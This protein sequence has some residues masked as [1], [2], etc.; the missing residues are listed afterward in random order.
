MR[1]IAPLLTAAV[2]AA[3]CA[4]PPDRPAA[5]PQS[6]TQLAQ[7]VMPVGLGWARNSINAVIFRGSSVASFGDMQYTA[8]YDADAHVILARRRLGSTTWEIVQT[9]YVGKVDDAH[10]AISLGVDGKGVLHMAWGGHNRPLLYAHAV[11]PGSLELSD[12]LAMTGQAEARVTYPQFY[13]L[14]DGD[15]LFL[16]RDG[17]SGSGDVMLNRY[18]VQSGVWSVVS[19][20]LIAG[21][22]LRNAYMN[23]LAVDARGGWHLSW[24]WRETPDVASNHDVMYAYSPD[25]GRSWRR[26]DGTE[27]ALPI[28]AANAEIA[29]PVPQGSELINQTSMTVD[30]RGRPLIATYWR[31]AGSDV[32]QYRLVW[33]DGTRWRMNEIGHR[34]QPFRLSG[35]GTRRIPISR[36]QLFA[37]GDSVYLVYRDEEQGPGIALAS[38]TDPQHEDWRVRTLYAPSV[39]M[40]EP[41]FDIDLWRSDR[42]LDLFVQRV[43]QGDAETQ[44]EM[45]PQMVSILEW[46]PGR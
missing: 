33:H 7:R 37:G 40:W 16:Y 45:P 21:D 39:G 6:A 25:E 38:S 13:R 19:H 26:S 31:D 42:R 1:R 30:G 14:A 41:S 15:L 20:P 43:G 44:E 27:Y 5:A 3:S 24:V 28:N 2:L 4:A 29:W 32:P 17:A 36:P 11:R 18:D 22:G 9:R 35:G 34:T 8:Y 12:T 23:T 46:S 10:D